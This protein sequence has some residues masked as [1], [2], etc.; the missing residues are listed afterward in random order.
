VPKFHAKGAKGA[1]IKSGRALWVS[2]GKD[3]DEDFLGRPLGSDYTD[4]AG[5]ALG[6]MLLIGNVRRSFAGKIFAPLRE[7]ARISTRSGYPGNL[8]NPS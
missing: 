4:E 3:F 5:R 7:I 2:L 8:R 1:K 6:E